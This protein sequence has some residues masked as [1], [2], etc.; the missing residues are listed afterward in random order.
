MLTKR[1]EKGE[2]NGVVTSDSIV[3]LGNF[4][5]VH[6]GH[7]EL[8]SELISPEYLGIVYTFYDH[9][10]N[11]I[12]GKG[13]VRVINTRAEKESILESLGVNVLFYE[14]FERVREMTPEEFVEEML[15]DTFHARRV[16][17]GFNYRF[18]KGNV[19]DAALLEKILLK[20][21]IELTVIPAVYYGGI[22][23]SSSEIRKALSDGDVERA[24]EMLGARYFISSTVRHGK[25]LGRSLGFPTVNL[26]LEEDRCSL[27]FGVYAAEL[28][29]D[30]KAYPSAV[31]VGLRP[32]VEEVKEPTVEA[33][34]IDF[35]GDLY[36]KNVRVEFVKRLRDE[37]RF[38]S[39]DELKIQVKKDTEECK[40]LFLEGTEY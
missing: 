13:S 22:P 7:R 28:L 12:N 31:N 21:G 5:G 6:I 15:V 39:L 36:G 14:D 25:A 3:A 4:D 33:H 38:S 29:V 23:V 35:D 37:K 19:G 8:I 26:L 2:T 11:V 34:I 27:R 32:T 10:L 24:G 40:R 20:Y 17:C 18:G 16:V 9:P 1:I 30:G